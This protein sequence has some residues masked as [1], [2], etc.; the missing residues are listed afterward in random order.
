MKHQI[1]IFIGYQFKSTQ[2]TRSE[3]DKII[4]D[5]FEKAESD[6]NNKFAD[7][8]KVRPI[9]QDM[10]SGKPICN[11]IFTQ[12]ENADFCIFELSDLNL[13]VM[14]ELGYSLGL[15][16]LCILMQYNDENI[17]NVPS[18]LSGLYIIKY[19]YETLGAKIAYEIYQNSIT[20]MNRRIQEI[21]YK[22][23]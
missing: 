19:D 23:Q 6:I 18:D 7:K 16:K 8:I 4:I 2:Y 12:I 9:L 5:S 11:Q 15:K 10:L 22:I 1:S 21:S 17:P 13:N 3:I 20:I 14:L